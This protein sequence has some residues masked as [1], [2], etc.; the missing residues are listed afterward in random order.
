MAALLYPYDAIKDWL[1]CW[2]VVIDAP[3]LI[4]EGYDEARGQSYIVDSPDVRYRLV[5]DPKLIEEIDRA[6]ND[7]LSLQ[8]AAKVFEKRGIDNTPLP[9]TVRTLLSLVRECVVQ[10]CAIG[11]FGEELAND[12]NFIKAAN[13]FVNR[14]GSIW[15]RST[16][17][18]HIA[19]RMVVKFLES[20]YSS[21]HDLFNALEPV[22]RRRIEEQ[23]LAAQGHTVPEHEDCIQ[24]IMELTMNSKP[25]QCILTGPWAAGRITHELMALWFGA[26]HT[27]AMATIFATEMPPSTQTYERWEATGAG[28]PFLDSFLKE[29][30]RLSP[31]DN[32]STRRKA[33][34]SMTL[35]DG[36]HAKAG[37]W[38]ATPLALT[39]AGNWAEPLEFHGFRH[40]VPE[41]LAA[42]EN[43][44]CTAYNTDVS[45]WQTW[46]TG[47]MAW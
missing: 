30:A 2:L 8:A 43:N 20:Y 39:D 26:V 24:Y 7:V 38:F 1:T 32:V 42:L 45:K 28:M 15:R 37:E 18:S 10:T 12:K 13:D 11:F 25:S 17:Y 29:S 31:L 22:A 33:L 36:T 21:Q 44:C 27:M 5:T 23:A 47:R 14:T 19:S 34:K 4:Q 16:I 3:R 35:S 46:G 6:P 9:K 40:V 41:Q